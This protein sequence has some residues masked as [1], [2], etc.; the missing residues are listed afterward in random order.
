MTPRTPDAVAP[1]QVTIKMAGENASTSLL[2]FDAAALGA[3]VEKITL[4]DPHLREDWGE[5][6]YRILLNSNQPVARG[7]FSYEFSRTE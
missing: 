2:K 6:I 4:T 1:G 5:D 7:K 3:K